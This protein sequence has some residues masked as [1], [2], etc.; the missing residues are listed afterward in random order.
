MRS[1]INHTLKAG[2]SDVPS[3]IQQKVEERISRATK[4]D[5]SFD[6][7]YYATLKGQLEYFDLR[8]LQDT[9]INKTLWTDFED[10][11]RNKEALIAKF[12]QLAEMRNGIRHS[13]TL[14]DIVLKE[15]E[16]ALLW[17]E[18]VLVFG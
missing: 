3:H 2:V 16:A 18:Q 12:G 13:R 1:V 4:K 14:S 7:E 5:A 17:F 11:F 15:G 8:E 10:R 9:I 6:S